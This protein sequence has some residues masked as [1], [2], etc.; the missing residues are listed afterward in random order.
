MKLSPFLVVGLSLTL[1]H[2]VTASGKGSK[3]GG[4]KA[5]RA[6]DDDDWTDDDERMSTDQPMTAPPIAMVDD[7][8]VSVGGDDYYYPTR[9]QKIARPFLGAFNNAVETLAGMGHNV[10]EP[11][12]FVEQLVE[13]GTFSAVYIYEYPP[14]AD[15]HPPTRTHTNTHATQRAT[16]PWTFWV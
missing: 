4:G 9:I 6:M 7:E 5:S 15:T 13:V 10:E 2:V 1:L 14:L 12:D 3:K 11:G 8:P 16:A